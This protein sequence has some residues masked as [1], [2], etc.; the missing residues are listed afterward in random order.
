M[1]YFRVDHPR[2]V[3]LEDGEGQLEAELHRVGLSLLPM[4]KEA[5]GEDQNY[6]G[7]AE[8]HDLKIRQTALHN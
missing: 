2:A 3:Q 8:P 1:H 6:G 7:H 4:V 5:D